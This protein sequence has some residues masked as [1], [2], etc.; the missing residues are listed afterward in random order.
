MRMSI[1]QINQ[2]II[3][4]TKVFLRTVIHELDLQHSVETAIALEELAAEIKA[5]QPVAQHD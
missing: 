1:D 4:A 5:E 3:T 2:E